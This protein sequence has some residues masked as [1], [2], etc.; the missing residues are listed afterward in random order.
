M[1][2]ITRELNEIQNGQFGRD[3]RMQIHTCLDR[4]NYQLEAQ[5]SG[6]DHPFEQY[7][8]ANGEV[9]VGTDGLIYL[10]RRES[11]NG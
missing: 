1:A 4:I 9:Y 2:D 5:D 3:I 7:V 6:E 8:D 11:G 10:C